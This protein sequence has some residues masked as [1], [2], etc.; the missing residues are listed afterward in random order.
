MFPYIDLI[1]Y[2]I[3]RDDIDKVRSVFDEAVKEKLDLFITSGGVSMGEKDLIKKFLELDGNIIFGRLNM[4][5]GKPTTFG[6]YKDLAVLGLPGNPVSFTVCTYL[7]VIYII[8]LFQKHEKFPYNRYNA[9]L[10]NDHKIDK[11]RPE[12]SRGM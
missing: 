11:E 2:G 7:L 6:K 3:V 10:I 1:D 4:K 12:Y 9:K 5:P 8:N